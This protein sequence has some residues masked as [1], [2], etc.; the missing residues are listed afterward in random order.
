MLFTEDISR[1]VLVYS[2]EVVGAREG[3]EELLEVA[4][5]VDCD[6]KLDKRLVG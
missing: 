1:T 5:W 3:H 4:R 2:I 6:E